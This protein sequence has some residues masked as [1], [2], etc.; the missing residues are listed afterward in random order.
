MRCHMEKPWELWQHLL[1][2]HPLPSH[3]RLD[4]PLHTYM[5]AHT[6]THKHTHLA[7]HAI[8]DLRL[9]FFEERPKFFCE[10]PGIDLGEGGGLSI[11]QFSF[12]VDQSLAK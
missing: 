12:T 10:A 7:V 4:L 5:C 11:G 2:D 3:Y 8:R 1:Q 9:L 6:C